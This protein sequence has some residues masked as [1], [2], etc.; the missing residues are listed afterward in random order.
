M[1]QFEDKAVDPK[2]W[3]RKDKL[4][5]RMSALKAVSIIYEQS[6]MN[7]DY[8]LDLADIY[9]NWIIQDQEWSTNDR[10]TDI[11]NSNNSELNNNNVVDILP[12]P[13]LKQKEWLDKIEAK[14]GFTAK[15]L[16]TKCK[17]YPNDKDSALEI[18][19]LMS[20]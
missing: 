5:S 15:E 12:T 1:P 4:S 17:K 7:G 14:Y 16:Y 2:I 9:Y 8:V 3:E 10:I 11:S 6:K 13:T 20:K 19:K 18:I